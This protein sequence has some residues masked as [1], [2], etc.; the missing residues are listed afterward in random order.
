[1]TWF[2]SME[3]FVSK[4]EEGICDKNS[5]VFINS[6]ANQIMNEENIDLFN[7]LYGKYLSNIVCEVT[8]QEQEDD[9]ITK[10]KVSLIKKWEGLI[11]LDDY[12]CGYN[13]E[14]A[15]LRISPN[16]VKIDMGIVRGVDKDNKRKRLIAN[17]ALYAKERDIILLAEGVETK[18]EIRT[19][20]S[21]GVQ[22]LQGYYIAKPSYDGIPPTKEV[23][24][25]LK[26]GLT[27]NTLVELGI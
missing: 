4:V 10:E 11:A 27:M 7:Q 23:V 20:V 1:M 19:L 12:G 17:L 22:L 25:E 21:L 3:A 8:E 9:Y 14:S 2:K 6:I 24:E 13:S 26:S 15:L 18:E 16:I 5:K